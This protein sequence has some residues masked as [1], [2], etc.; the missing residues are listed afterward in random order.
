MKHSPQ[1]IIA[2][3]NAATIKKS[4]SP[5]YSIPFCYSTNMRSSNEL[6]EDK[7]KYT[8]S[9]VIEL[10]KKSHDN[11]PSNESKY[12]KIQPINKYLSKYRF[13]SKKASTVDRY[14]GNMNGD[15]CTSSSS[16]STC[17]IAA[18]QPSSSS[19][20]D[21]NGNRFAM[22]S[23]SNILQ[24]PA[25]SFQHGPS[26]VGYSIMNHVSSPESAYSTGY[27]TDG[28]SPGKRFLK[29]QRSKL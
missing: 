16:A 6:L 9:V 25:P 8:S 22:C 5:L 10:Q 13:F 21:L 11:L 18:L 7:I 26:K 20:I 19:T 29:N 15:L 1:P 4:Y 28:T 17:N 23:T 27:S 12:G 24:N 14:N 2:S 3:K